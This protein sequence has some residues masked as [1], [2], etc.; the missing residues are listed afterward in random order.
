MLI[1]NHLRIEIETDNGL[2]GFDST[3][4][5]G[6]NI[7]ASDDNTRGKT[8][9]IEAILYCLGCEE[10]IGGQGSKVLTPAYTSELTDNMGN[11]RKVLQSGAYL[12]IS[13]GNDIITIYRAIKHQARKEK[14]ITVFNS[15]LDQIRFPNTKSKDYYV[16]SAGSATNA[17]GYHSFL[18]EFLSLKLPV[19]YD[20]NDTPHQLYIQQILAALFIEQKGGWIDIL[21]RAPYF[22]INQ[23]KK[24]V[25]EYW[26]GLST[27]KDE[28]ERRILE[29][30][31]ANLKLE[32]RHSIQEVE[33]L[34]QMHSGSI[35]NISYDPEIM[36]D[37]QIQSIMVIIEKKTIG[38]YI[39]T[40]ESELKE[41]ISF[42]PKIK[43]N[44][45]KLQQELQSA[46]EK[47]IKIREDIKE[48]QERKIVESQNL[49]K[50]K[51]ILEQLNNDIQNNKD[52]KKLKALGSEMGIK[53]AKNICPLCNQHIDDSLLL[54][55]TPVMSIEENISH[56]SSQKSMVEFSISSHCRALEEIEK[57]IANNES[58]LFT[59]EKLALSLRSDLS[60]VED[61]YSETIVLKRVEL[62][63]KISS[64]KTI[65]K[66]L[67]ELK[68]SIT[69]L[70]EKYRTVIAKKEEITN[71]ENTSNITQQLASFKNNFI[72]FLFDFGYKSVNKS[73]R[74]DISPISLLPSIDDFDMKFGA[75]AS[76]NVRM[77]WAYTLSILIE[78]QNTDHSLNFALFDE[79]KQ[80]S[81]IKENLERFVDTI[82][83]IC[84]K[85]CCQIVLCITA[86]DNSADIVSK[87]KEKGSNVINIHDWAFRKI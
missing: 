15:E 48:L 57:I 62:K 49:R 59:I 63:Q 82:I 13:N 9:I 85:N 72:R 21:N 86:T 47:I 23:V 77:I 44:Y 53:Y 76:D 66:K 27:N 79:P 39:S 38:E 46:E 71:N 18:N 55:E 36:T 56:L 3:F 81:I 17:D 20:N 75:S 60:T 84:N 5:K 10:I 32:W 67:D 68:M 65:L 83:K 6:L 52:A 69:Q 29:K 34:V 43:D 8:S 12:E 73:E 25:M 2:Y 22:S 16:Q 14:L 7:I 26:L 41:V 87:S 31:L 50:Q 4:S 54:F 30:E 61:N 1:V 45:E 28:H 80:H 74:I 58:S 42:S 19:V 70:S 35:K 33:M 24:R 51:H 78:S 64:L 11:A 40:L 37:E